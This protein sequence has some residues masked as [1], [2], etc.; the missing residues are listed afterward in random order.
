MFISSL[1]RTEIISNKY[2]IHFRFPSIDGLANGII[3]PVVYARE[4]IQIDEKGR[5]ASVYFGSEEKKYV[6]FQRGIAYSD[7]Q[8]INGVRVKDGIVSNYISS[9][10]MDA[11]GIS[12]GKYVKD[13][14]GDGIIDYKN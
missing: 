3:V 8:E 11:D 13:I 1:K 5:I 14:N 12:W 7:A 4:D 9:I 2:Q 10:D 6:I